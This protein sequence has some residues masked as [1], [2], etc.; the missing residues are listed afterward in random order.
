MMTAEGEAQGV[1]RDAMEM[2]AVYGR[3]SRCVWVAGVEVQID[4]GSVSVL[5]P[6][7]GLLRRDS[8]NQAVNAST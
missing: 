6:G 8:A 5:V 1:R 2:Q 7:T 3:R 4:G